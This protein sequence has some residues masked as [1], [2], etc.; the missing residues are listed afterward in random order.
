[1]RKKRPVPFEADVWDG[2]ND[3]LT[4]VSVTGDGGTPDESDGLE[5]TVAATPGRTMSLFTTII[6]RYSKLIHPDIPRA[7]VFQGSRV[8]RS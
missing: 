6:S 2:L 3:G 8:V 1:V 4:K 7:D 5:G